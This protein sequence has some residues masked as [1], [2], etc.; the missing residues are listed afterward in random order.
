MFGVYILTLA[1]LLIYTS[2][3]V[4]KVEKTR[5]KASGSLVVVRAIAAIAFVVGIIFSGLNI[6][7]VAALK[8]QQEPLMVCSQMEN[9]E[10]QV[11]CGTNSVYLSQIK[12]NSHL[13]LATISVAFTAI[14]LIILLY[15]CGS[16]R[17]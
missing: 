10:I 16:H 13:I 15:S 8:S 9:K 4:K 2:G 12:Y 1:D 17:E 7:E 6:Y 5:V 3:M 14:F 11:V